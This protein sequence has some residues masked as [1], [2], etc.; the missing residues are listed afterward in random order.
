M[1]KQDILDKLESLPSDTIA[2]AV[3]DG[4]VSFGELQEEGLAKNKQSEIK[5]IIANIANKEDN[6]W[7]EAKRVNTDAAYRDYLKKYDSGKYREEARNLISALDE[8]DWNKA[9][10]SGDYD[11]YIQKHPQGKHKDEA[12]SAKANDSS[13]E[14]IWKSVDKTSKEALR[15]F[16]KAF[17]NSKYVSE[18]KKLYGKVKVDDP[19]ER[20]VSD[21]INEK[22]RDSQCVLAQRYLS[23]GG[24]TMRNE[25]HYQAFLNVLKTNHN[26]L[27]SS[28]IRKLLD[29]ELLDQFDLEEIGISENNIEMAK[30]PQKYKAKRFGVPAPLTKISRLSTEVYF[31]GM[32]SSGKSCAIGS[33][34]NAINKGQIVTPT[35][36]TECQGFKYLNE[37]RLVFDT[38]NN[39]IVLPE[40][41]SVNATY[42]MG[43]ALKPVNADNEKVHPIT[44]IDL[45]GELFKCMYKQSPGVKMPLSDSEQQ[46]FDTLN[47]ILLNNV[48]ENQKIHFFVVEYGA[49]H[50]MDEGCT[51]DVYLSSAIQYI[52]EK[53][54]LKKATNAIYV[55]VTKADL[56]NKTNRELGPHIKAYVEEHY[57]AFYDGLVDICKENDINGK[58]GRVGCIPFSL[59]DVCFQDFCKVNTAPTTTVINEIL[60]NSKTIDNSKLGRFFKSLRS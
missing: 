25:A 5:S 55:L 54:I 18:A 37:L 1:T 16:I 11:S 2:Q 33:I 17:P 20:I 9:S 12:I 50:K 4:V 27:S 34:L 57:K 52:K 26:L 53:G 39:V 32:P 45:A 31:W 22:D 36:D 19:I 46:A 23:S 29:L 6:D 38:P 3:V 28:S 14:S 49:E 21:I 40:R 30:D 48:T 35:Y 58:E 24:S 41:T 44:M 15:G 51:P 42:E 8:A 13:D 43:M 56:A 10:A 47:N 7:N 60:R 59:G